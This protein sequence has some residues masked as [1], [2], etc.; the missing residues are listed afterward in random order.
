MRCFFVFQPLPNTCVFFRV[1][2][3]LRLVYDDML[4]LVTWRSKT[5]TG[6]APWGH[7][8]LTHRT[9]LSI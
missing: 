8:F 1:I 9:N 6:L 2:S 7:T 3:A 5:A 4:H